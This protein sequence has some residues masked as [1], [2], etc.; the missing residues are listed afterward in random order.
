MES[1]GIDV[2]IGVLRQRERIAVFAMYAVMAISALTVVFE[3]MEI[4]GIVDLVQEPDTPMA[5]VYIGVLLINFVIY[6]GAVIAVAMWIHRGHRNLHEAGIPDLKFSPGWA[7][8]WYF[9]P[10]AFLFMPF[11]AMRELWTVS[12][13]SSDSFSAS[14]P[15]NLGMWWAFWIIGNILG[16]VSFRTSDMGDGSVGLITGLGS[17]VCTIVAA[18]LLMKIMQ[19]I[20]AAQTDGIGVAQV[21]E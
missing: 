12:H 7:V 14:A 1:E 16:N 11:Q 5:L 10:I 15:G 18:W 17:S 13:N 9:V 3:V 6:I 21:F 4:A 19:E 8:G 2:G 20:T